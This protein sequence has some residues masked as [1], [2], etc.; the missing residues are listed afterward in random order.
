ML[1]IRKELH[2][3]LFFLAPPPTWLHPQLAPPPE[4]L[5]S[6]PGSGG[7]DPPSP[8]PDRTFYQK[9]NKRQN[10]FIF[11]LFHHFKPDLTPPNLDFHIRPWWRNP[12]ILSS[13]A[14]DFVR[15]QNYWINFRKS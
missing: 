9:C 10:F 15:I 8:K 2:T 7:S 4:I 12:Y 3:I 13:N 14:H 11:V 6:A 5:M 1:S